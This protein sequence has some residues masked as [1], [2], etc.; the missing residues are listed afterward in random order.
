M[1]SIRSSA[2]LR[3]ALDGA[4]DPQI[5]RLLELRRDQLYEEGRDLGDLAHLIIAHRGDTLDDIEREAGIPLATNI[6]DGSRLGERGF[7][8][9]FELIERHLG[10]WIEAV[11]ILSDDGFA[12]SLFVPDLI[13]TDPSLLKLLRS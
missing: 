8:H 1:I 4:L 12:V 3:H 10:G 7:T 6:V 9:S 5:R 13:T 2:D 11:L